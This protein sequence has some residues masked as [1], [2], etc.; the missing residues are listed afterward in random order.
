MKFQ[1]HWTGVTDLL[2]DDFLPVPITCTF[3]NLLIINGAPS[4]NLAYNFGA[5]VYLLDQT[6]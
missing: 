4:L 5:V 3:H 2:L 1:G 6:V